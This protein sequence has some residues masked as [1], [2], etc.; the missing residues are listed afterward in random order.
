MPRALSVDHVQLAMPRG[1]EQSA[2]DFYTG[3]LGLVEIPKPA[4]LVARGGV[5]F[6]CGELQVHLGVENPFHPAKKA[7]PAFVV[8]DLASFVN[9]LRG[10]GLPAPT[11]VEKIAGGAR[12][13]TED[14]FGN[15]IELIQTHDSTTL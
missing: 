2:R 7:H 1:E 9:L 12:I 6:R 3:V 4:D 14:P 11:H 8:D 13:F 5:W 10:R 15:R